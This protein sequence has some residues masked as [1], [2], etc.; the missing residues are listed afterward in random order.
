MNLEFKP[1]EDSLVNFVTYCAPFLCSVF[2]E[3]VASTETGYGNIS[4]G[5][6]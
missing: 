1:E 5:K 2:L 6:Q 4:N 3:S